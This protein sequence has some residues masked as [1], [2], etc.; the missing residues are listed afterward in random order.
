MGMVWLGRRDKGALLNWSDHGL[1][2]EKPS[3]SQDLAMRFTTEEPTGGAF[4]ASWPA[5]SKKKNSGMYGDECV[6]GAK[7][8]L[9]ISVS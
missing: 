9:F 1:A 6:V 3:A 8:L 4:A 5:S 2:G 7:W